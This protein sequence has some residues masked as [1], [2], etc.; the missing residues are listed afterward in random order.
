MFFLILVSHG[1]VLA[2]PDCAPV[3]STGATA[4][5]GTAWPETIQYKNETGYAMRV[6]GC[7]S[8]TIAANGN[9]AA[10]QASQAM[11]VVSIVDAML[12]IGGSVA[13]V[14]GV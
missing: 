5:S 2:C 14:A 11:T 9:L 3:D 12:F 7:V 6:A 1:V 13:G 8:V 10:T 4:I